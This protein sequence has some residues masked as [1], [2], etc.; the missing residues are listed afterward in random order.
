MVES[1]PPRGKVSIGDVEAQFE[2][3]PQIHAATLVVRQVT[4]GRSKANRQ[5]TRR[6]RARRAAVIRK[7]LGTIEEE[8]DNSGRQLGIVRTRIETWK[9]LVIAKAQLEICGTE[10]EIVERSIQEWRPLCKVEEQPALV[11]RR[12]ETVRRLKKIWGQLD[13]VERRL[14]V[15]ESWLEINDRQGEIWKEFDKVEHELRTVERQLE[16][17]DRR[18]K[19]SKQLEVAETQLELFGRQL[20]IFEAKIN[21]VRT[22]CKA[23]L[24][25]GTG[26]GEFL[27]LIEGTSNDALQSV[28]DTFPERKPRWS[29]EGRQRFARER[30]N[31]RKATMWKSMSQTASQR[32]SL[33]RPQ[34]MSLSESSSLLAGW[35]DTKDASEREEY[36]LKNKVSHPLSSLP[37]ILVVYLRQTANPKVC[38]CQVQ[39]IIHIDSI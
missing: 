4:T 7:Q 28:A 27:P 20:E 18:I 8:L 16:I 31:L 21:L 32:Q 39:C 22:G 37:L 38:Y 29:I 30:Q 5:R 19:V 26:F 23:V 1:T 34:K 25:P 13:I 24:D 17:I 12:L 11:V 6:Q 2:D 35:L 9:Q 10:L 36:W 3:L 33:K 15:V 14:C